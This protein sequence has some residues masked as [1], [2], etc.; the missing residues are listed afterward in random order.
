MKKI[1]DID[2]SA[3]SAVDVCDIIKDNVSAYG[4]SDLIIVR[5]SEDNAYFAELPKDEVLINDLIKDY[6]R[7]FN[8]IG[9]DGGDGIGKRQVDI[10]GSDLQLLSEANEGIFVINVK[11][12][13]RTLHISIC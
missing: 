10:V 9:V 12:E 4:E 1:I 11:D 3:N 8:G 13:E 6:K 5:L 2:I 7:I